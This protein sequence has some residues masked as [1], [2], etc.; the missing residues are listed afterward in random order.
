MLK[1]VLKEWGTDG[2]HVSLKLYGIFGLSES[3]S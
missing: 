2:A 3:Y 1:L